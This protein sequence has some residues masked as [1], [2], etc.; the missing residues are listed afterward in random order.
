MKAVRKAYTE[1]AFFFAEGMFLVV[2]AFGGLWTSIVLF[3]L[4]IG[5]GHGY[6]WIMVPIGLGF[7]LLAF[8]GYLFIRVVH[9]VFNRVRS[10]DN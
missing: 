4:S 3:N 8:C 7:S 2:C 10:S 5:S 1:T 9:Q 6:S